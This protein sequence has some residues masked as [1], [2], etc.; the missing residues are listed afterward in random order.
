[1]TWWTLYDS[2]FPI[3]GRIVYNRTIADFKSF[4][5]RSFARDFRK[6]LDILLLQDKLLGTRSEFRVGRWIEQARNLGTT[7]RRKDLYRVECPRAD[8]HL[9]AIVFALMT[10]VCVTMPIRNGTVFCAISI[11]NVGQ[12]NGK[13]FQGSTGW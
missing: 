5:K 11:I 12:P 4:D 1:M 3:K 7:P 10:V 6:F 2:L 9:G 13:L 8:N